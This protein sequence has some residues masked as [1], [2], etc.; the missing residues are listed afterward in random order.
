MRGTSRPGYNCPSLAKLGQPWAW[1]SLARLGQAFGL[2]QVTLWRRP[3]FSTMDVSPCTPRGVTIA[4]FKPVFTIS[5]YL[6]DKQEDKDE[7]QEVSKE[8]DEETLRDEDEE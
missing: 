1:P 6:E 8:A 5:S 2:R 3:L 4:H 7:D